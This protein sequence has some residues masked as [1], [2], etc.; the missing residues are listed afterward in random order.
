M[1]EQEHI[2]QVIKRLREERRLSKKR[3][4]RAS[5]SSPT[6]TSSR[7]SRDERSPSEKVLRF[8]S[9]GRCSCQRGSS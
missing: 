5:H 7:S 6:P 4:L 2:G 9:R 1:A 8:D 3:A